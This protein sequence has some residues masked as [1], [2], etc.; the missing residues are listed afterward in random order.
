MSKVTKTDYKGFIKDW[1]ERAIETIKDKRI[2]GK[3]VAVDVAVPDE[4]SST[5]EYRVKMFKLG[6]YMIVKNHNEEYRYKLGKEITSV[7]YKHEYEVEED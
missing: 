7:L 5:A 3:W 4:W 2:N 6:L 1:R